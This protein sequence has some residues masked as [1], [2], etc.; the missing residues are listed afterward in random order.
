MLTIIT[1]LS[2]TNFSNQTHGIG[3]VQ[4]FNYVMPEESRVKAVIKFLMEN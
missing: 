1:L 4:I 2:E 3:T